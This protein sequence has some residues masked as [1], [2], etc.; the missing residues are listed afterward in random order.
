MSCHMRILNESFGMIMALKLFME[1]VTSYWHIRIVLQVCSE[2]LKR[3]KVLFTLTSIEFSLP[4]NDI[5]YLLLCASTC[6]MI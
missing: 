5:T 4:G 1:Y 3:V 2:L 6:F